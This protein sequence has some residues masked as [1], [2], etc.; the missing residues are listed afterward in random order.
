MFHN[1]V[2]N[3]WNKLPDSV[4]LAASISSFKR[5]LLSFV[6]NVGFDIFQSTRF[7][8]SSKYCRLL[9]LLTLFY[10]HLL[11]EVAASFGVRSGVFC[12]CT[13]KL[14]DWLIDNL[15]SYLETNI[16][17]LTIGGK[18]GAFV[19]KTQFSGHRPTDHHT[20]LLCLAG[21]LVLISQQLTIIVTYYCYYLSLVPWCQWW[22]IVK[23]NCN[24]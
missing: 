1:R 11:A 7:F 5:L 3:F 4:V 8:F 9:L 10:G 20:Q 13:N 2:I 19:Q 14:I 21:A 6:V 22:V 23:T 15:P 12:I 24:C 17:A 18:G 16:V